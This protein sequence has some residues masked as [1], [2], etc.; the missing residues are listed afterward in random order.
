MERVSVMDGFIDLLI[1][2]ATVSDVQSDTYIDEIESDQSEGV[3]AKPS[4]G[5]YLKEKWIAVKTQFS[6]R[7]FIASSVW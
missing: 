3:V 1:Y 6:L 4:K 7:T 5:S 2:W